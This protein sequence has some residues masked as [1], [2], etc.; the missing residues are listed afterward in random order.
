MWCLGGPK[1]LGQCGPGLQRS[2]QKVR[3]SK[4]VGQCTTLPFHVNYMSR[5]VLEQNSMLN[6][7]VIQQQHCTTK[8]IIETVY[9]NIETVYHGFFTPLLN[10]VWVGDQYLVRLLLSHGG[11]LKEVLDCTL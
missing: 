8:L 1:C 2:S 3:A 10:D 6:F 7:S 11:R 5:V 9:A 4:L